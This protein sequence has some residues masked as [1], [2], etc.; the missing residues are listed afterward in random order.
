[1]SDKNLSGIAEWLESVPNNTRVPSLNPA[2]VPVFVSVTRN[3]G[4]VVTINNHGILG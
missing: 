1:M 2:Q 3:D 4:Y